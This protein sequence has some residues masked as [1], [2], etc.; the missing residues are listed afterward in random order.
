MANFIRVNVAK[1]Y[2][3]YE[4]TTRFNPHYEETRVRKSVMNT[5]ASDIGCTVWS[6]DGVKLYL[7]IKLDESVCSQ[8]LDVLLSTLPRPC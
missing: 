7:P 4:Y 1:N 3:L 8:L 2:T 6:F 5:I